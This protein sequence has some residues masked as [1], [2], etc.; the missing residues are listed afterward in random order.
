MDRLDITGGRPLHG[1]VQIGG[2]KNAALPLL[3]A[4]LLSDQPLTLGNVPGV[5]DI[6]SMVALLRELGAV[7]DDH[8][9]H[10]LTVTARDLTRA[11]A[12]YDV[13]RRMRAS[14]LVLAPLLARQGRARI[15]RP[16]G[17]AIGT[18]PVD[19]HL[20]TLERLGAVLSTAGGM[21]EAQAPNGLTGARI[22]LPFASVGATHA[23]IMAATAAR[24]ESEIVNGAREPEIVDLADC[25]TTMGARIDGAGTSIIRVQGPTV[26]R[27]AEHHVAADRIEAGTYLIAAVLTGGMLEVTGARL[28]HLGAL[29]QVLSEAGAAIYP[30]DRGLVA[31]RTGPLRAVDI[32]TGPFPAF[33]TDLQAQFTAL[34]TLAQGVAVIREGV[35]ENRFMHVPELQRMGADISHKGAMA[36]VR[37]VQALHGADVMASDLR[38]SASLVLAGLA[39]RG[40]TRV[41]RVY[42]LD[43]GYEALDRKLS[44]CGADVRRVAEE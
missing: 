19:L 26:W 34:M 1:S 24:G 7:V 30:S 14:F 39:A 23:A 11:E 40:V 37:G 32:S 16:G 2:A 44:R 35:F 17:C 13:V 41:H 43:R 10:R 31:E 36:V 25:L 9:P 12:S 33:P 28:E 27:A 38:A 20:S 15:S 42:H 5:S 8:D 21:I 4:A 6:T 22:V 3:A 18:R 29:C